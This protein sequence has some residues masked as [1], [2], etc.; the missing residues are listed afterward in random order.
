MEMQSGKSPPPD[1]PSAAL[2]ALLGALPDIVYILD[3][4]GRFLSLNASA[5]DM[6]YEP[7]VLKGRHFSEIL[8]PEDRER[9]SRAAVVAKLRESGDPFPEVAPKLF[10][11]RRSGSRMTR[12]LEVRVIH[13]SSGETLHCSVNAY[14]DAAA[15]PALHALLEY[16]GRITI[17]VI[18]DVTTAYLYRKSLEENLAAKERALRE[19]HR[20]V[21]DNLQTVASLIHVAEMDI[22]SQGAKEELRRIQGKVRSLAIVHEALF[23]SERLD[24]VDCAQYF[25]RLIQ[26]LRESYGQVGSPVELR[27]LVGEGIRLGAELLSSLAMMASELVIGAY[28]HAFPRGAEGWIELRVRNISGGIALEVADNGQRPTQERLGSQGLSIVAE[29]ARNLGSALTREW[30]GGTTFQVAVALDPAEKPF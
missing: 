15:D 14:G 9:V 20:R 7:E 17:G 21:K 25:S 23:Q 3:E 12:N 28:L 13:G 6:G 27:A 29:M 4:D 1:K 22:P 8:H 18:R 19:I 26:L 24:G 2:E 16:R 30:D 5:R 10:D 11:E